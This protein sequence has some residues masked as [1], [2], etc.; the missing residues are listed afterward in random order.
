[1]AIENLNDGVGRKIVEALKMQSDE[2]SDE[3]MIVEED[4]DIELEEDDTEIIQNTNNERFYDNNAYEPELDYN[5]SNEYQNLNKSNLQF[6]KVTNPQTVIDTAFNNSLNQN[7]A[8]NY[9]TTPEDI[10]YPANITVLRQLIAK[11]PSGVSKQ[12]GAI[13]IKQTMEALGISMNSV[14]QEAK[15][16]QD[17]LNNNTKECQRN[18]VEYRKQIGI[19]ESKTQQYQ[20]QSAIMN[21]IISLFL[22]T[23]K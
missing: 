10:D 14:L 3:N 1:M 4:S 9:N 7:L 2:P 5:I 20:R 22:H 6:S 8:P 21:D 16:V 18:I 11:L 19:L 13:I 15:Q 17:M 23:G 12:T